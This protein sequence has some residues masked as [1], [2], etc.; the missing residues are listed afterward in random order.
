MLQNNRRLSDT[1]WL[2]VN[3]TSFPYV[4]VIE[5]TNLEGPE[6]YGG[7]HI[8][9]LS[10]YLDQNAPL[11]RMPDH[12]V[13]EHSLP[14]LQEMFPGFEHDWVDD[15]RVWRADYAQPVVTPGYAS[16][17]PPVRTELPGLFM[18][19]MAQVFPEDRGTNYAIR[20]G[21]RAAQI[22]AESLARSGEQE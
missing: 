14:Y 2:N 4:G 10:K 19:S 5:H 17:M 1:Y 22:V 8:V 20:D 18:A 9:Y 3:D 15:Y 16:R 12:Q 6:Q 7:K 13:Y 21:R 11:Y